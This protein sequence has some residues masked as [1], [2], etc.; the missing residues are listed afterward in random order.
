MSGERGVTFGE[1]GLVL[2]RITTILVSVALIV[3]NDYRLHTG[4]NMLLDTRALWPCS[5]PWI[6]TF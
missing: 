4:L 2:L 5:K 1:L 6:L 3:S